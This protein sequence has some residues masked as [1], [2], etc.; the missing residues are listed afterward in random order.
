MDTIRVNNPNP[1]DIGVKY[2]DGREQNIKAHSFT[3]MSEDNIAYLSSTCTLF[4]RGMLRI[5]KPEAEKKIFDEIGIVKEDNPA[6]MDDVDL[7]KKF[8]M[9]AAKI[10]AWLADIDDR[11]LLSRILEKAEEAD[12]AASKMKVIR[13]KVNGAEEE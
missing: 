9:S 2:F 1:F 4:E 8:A 10:K 11:V 6:F 5:D 7:K 3:M 12:L 13:E